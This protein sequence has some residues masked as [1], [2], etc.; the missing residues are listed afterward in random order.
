MSVIGSVIGLI[1]AFDDGNG[2][3][4][5]MYEATKD[6]IHTVFG[7]TALDLF[8]SKIKATEGRYYFEAGID[9]DELIAKMWESI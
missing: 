6:L 5:V 7:I 4:A 1:H 2:M 8:V 3:P 9:I